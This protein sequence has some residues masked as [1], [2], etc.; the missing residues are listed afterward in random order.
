MCSS[1]P[2]N[3]IYV[4]RV[5]TNDLETAFVAL[6]QRLDVATAKIE[7]AALRAQL[8]KTSD[9]DSAE[10]LTQAHAAV[11]RNL[12][13]RT[14]AHYGSAL[15]RHMLTLAGQPFLQHASPLLVVLKPTAGT[16]FGEN[17]MKAANWAEKKNG[18]TPQELRPRPLK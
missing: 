5:S 16:D 18:I 17:I 1:P 10:H 3:R 14:K 2:S 6:A 7:A 11:A 9:S 15:V 12:L 4:G 8:E 13:K